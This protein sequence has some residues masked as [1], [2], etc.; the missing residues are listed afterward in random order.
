MTLA[1]AAE[2]RLRPGVHA[3]LDYADGLVPGSIAASVLHLPRVTERGDRDL[4]PLL[5]WT[6]ALHTHGFAHVADIMVGSLYPVL[7]QGCAFEELISFYGA[8]GG[9]QTRAFIPAPGRL[10]LP[11]EPI[12]GA[13]VRAVLS[14]WRR[15]LQGAG[16]QRDRPAGI[17]EE[18]YA[19]R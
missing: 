18:A 2:R 1:Y 13:A 8:L 6:Y 3:P 10:P 9:P 4:G 11:A 12:A 5:R 17:G 7:G 19:E 14:G 16:A 15:M